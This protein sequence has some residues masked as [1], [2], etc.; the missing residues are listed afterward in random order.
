MQ[1]RMVVNHGLGEGILPNSLIRLLADLRS[2]LAVDQR[3]QLLAT[4][5]SHVAVYNV[6]A[7]FP[8]REGSK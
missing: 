1:T 7:C 5:T 4:K 3:H 2:S 6:A 8:R